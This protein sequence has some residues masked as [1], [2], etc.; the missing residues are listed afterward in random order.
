LTFGLSLAVIYGVALVLVP[1]M[2]T[3]ER[4]ELIAGALT[5]TLTLLVPLL[6]YLTL[7]YWRGWP[8]VTVLP[9]FI[10]SFLRAGRLIPD[11]HHQ[12]LDLVEYGA[13]AAEIVLVG[14]LGYRTFQLR[15]AYREQAASGLDVYAGLR[16][17]AQSIL[18]PV[19]GNMLA[20]EMTVF[21]YLLF[22]WR[23]TPTDRPL[24]F[25]YHRKT[26]Y[27]AIVAV[28]MLAVVAELFGMHLLIS[29]WSSVVAW[30]VTVLSIYAMLWL[31]GDAHAIR[32][33]PIQL[34]ETMLLLRVGLRS[35][36]DVPLESIDSFGAPSGGALSRRTPGYLKAVLLG[37]PSFRVELN[38][39]VDALGPYG[40]TTKATTID[41]QVDEPQRL[42]TELRKSIAAVSGTRTEW[43]FRGRKNG[44]S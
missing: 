33:R 39:P 13:V 22:G 27:L 36:I 11:T 5:L 14:F 21:Y 9:V 17:S 1:R 6:Y 30:I 20:Y 3:F 31:I 44:G 41:V 40:L 7:V 32:L 25:S 42:E 16:Q 2:A 18:G 19:A 4:S 12:M 10:G 26:A 23:R 43:R 15:R 38:T 24:S 28:V 29:L 8:V 34:T 37:G 35:T